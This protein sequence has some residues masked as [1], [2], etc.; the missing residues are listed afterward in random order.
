MVGRAAE[1]AKTGSREIGAVGRQGCPVSWP[2]VQI[3]HV[4]IEIKATGFEH[5]NV[6]A[7]CAQLPCDRD[8]GCPRPHETKVRMDHL[9]GTYLL[10]IDEHVDSL[11]S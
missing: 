3:L 7:R 6:Q 1:I 8:A 4:Q 2:R 9:A 10:S 5:A 11:S